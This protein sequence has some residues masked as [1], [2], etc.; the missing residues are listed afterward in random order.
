MAGRLN[1]NIN[2]LYLGAAVAVMG[3]LWYLKKNGV[4]GTTYNLASGAVGALAD[5]VNGVVSGTVVGAGKV[6]GIPETNSGQ[7]L[8]DRQAGDKWAASF[9]CPAKTYIG[10]L[11]DGAPT[12][13]TQ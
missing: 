10:W 8:A 6:V 5:A 13:V 1:L 2:P 3:A 9:S 11:W 4:Q 12:N 7:C